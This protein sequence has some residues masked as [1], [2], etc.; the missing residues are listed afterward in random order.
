MERRN[1]KEIVATGY[2]KV[3]FAYQEDNCDASNSP[4][5]QWLGELTTRLKKGSRVLDLGCGCGIPVACLLIEH[6]VVTGV[7]ISPVQIERARQLGL[8]AEFICADMVTLEFEEACF[9]AITCLY[10]IIH[11]PLVEQP[12]LIGKM[13]KWLTYGGYLLVIVGYSAW[14]GLEKDWLGVEGGLM[15]WS[16]AD[17][18]TYRAWFEEAGFSIVSEQFIPEGEG[19]HCLLLVQKHKP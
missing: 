4:Y 12:E 2:D 9:E 3:S 18:G 16:H 10:S 17:I 19:G 13:Y 8:K 15:Y 5:V 7:D 14:T 1:P 6:F 11:L